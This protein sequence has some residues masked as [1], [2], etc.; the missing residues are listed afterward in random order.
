MWWLAVGC[1]MLANANTALAL[2]GDG[3]W[4]FHYYLCKGQWID[5]HIKILLRRTLNYFYGDSQ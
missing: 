4:Q 2:A 1:G 3:A 5:L